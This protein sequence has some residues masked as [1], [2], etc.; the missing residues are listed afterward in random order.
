MS[1]R[2]RIPVTLITLLAAGLLVGG[3]GSSGPGGGVA[4]GG[5]GWHGSGSPGGGSPGGGSVAVRA[6]AGYA[7][8]HPARSDG[9]PDR[10]PAEADPAR[11]PDS[12]FAMDVDSASYGYARRQL[13]QGLRPAPDTVRPEEFVNAFRQDYPQPSGDGFTLTQDGA[14][15]PPEHHG[16]PEGDIRLLRIG[17]QTR[18]DGPDRPDAALTFVIDV[19]GSMGDPGKLDMVKRA[20]QSFLDQVRPT[21]SVAIVTFDDQAH[22]VR[23]MTPV[24]ERADL[25]AAV[26]RLEAGGDTNLEAGLVQG[27]RVARQGFRQGMTNRVV[28]LSDG[29]ANTGDTEAA[30]ILDRVRDEAAKQITLLGVGVGNDYGDRLMEQL[31]DHGDGFVVYVS[32]E[33]AARRTFVQTL[34]AARSV[35]ALDAKV[36][37]TFDP[38]TVAGYR[39]IGYDDRAL[40]STDFRDD[41]VDGGEVAAGHSVTALYTVRLRD[42]ARGQVAHTQLRWQDPHTRAAVETGAE[43][44]VADLDRRLDQ[45]GARLQV[46]YAAAY[47]AERLRQSRHGSEVSA[48][49]LA[50]IADAAASTTEDDAVRELA[51]MIR[52]VPG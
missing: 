50:R 5:S 3:C 19:S 45:A 18:D 37:V 17:L 13:E 2:T 11:T 52:N 21:D 44:T 41:R 15:L 10:P 28:L 30:P 33:G 24:R 35:R 31:A 34:P 42:G 27:Y 29:L 6:P 4:T 14:R 39:L 20:L 51:R 43:V 12:T 23:A 49:Y 46:C 22:V 36:Q 25:R 7:S 1:V 48:T 47:L 40:A 8:A 38:R 16:S 9:G 32:D 26:D